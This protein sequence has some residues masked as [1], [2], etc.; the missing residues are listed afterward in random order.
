M[1]LRHLE[2]IGYLIFRPLSGHSSRVRRTK[3]R[4]T[5]HFL[6]PAGVAASASLASRLKCDRSSRASATGIVEACLPIL[7]TLEGMERHLRRSIR[8]AF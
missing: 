6:M 2:I 1:G 5:L 3:Q 7:L 8:N 4:W